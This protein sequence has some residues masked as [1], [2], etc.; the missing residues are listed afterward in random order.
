MGVCF[1][2]SNATTRVFYFEKL[3]RT[4][5]GPV[6]A[7]CRPAAACRSGRFLPAASQFAGRAFLLTAAAAGFSACTRRIFI[8]LNN[9]LPAESDRTGLVPG[10]ESRPT[11]SS[12]PSLLFSPPIFISYLRTLSC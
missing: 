9:S 8:T 10:R 5:S 4:H 2:V 6:R 12:G 11:L 1:V 7:A 3:D